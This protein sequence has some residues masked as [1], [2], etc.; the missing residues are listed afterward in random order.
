MPEVSD[1]RLAP[2]FDQARRCNFSNV[3]EVD[4]GDSINAIMFE[5]EQ[6]Q[7]RAFAVFVASDDGGQFIAIQHT[8]VEAFWLCQ[9]VCE[10]VNFTHASELKQAVESFRRAPH[11]MPELVASSAF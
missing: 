4:T 9:E 3:Q 8:N 6:P 10:E 11:G 7:E 2:I 5:T 1:P